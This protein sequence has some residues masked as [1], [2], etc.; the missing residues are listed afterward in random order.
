MV[1]KAGSFFV[2]EQTNS[3]GQRYGVRVRGGDLAVKAVAAG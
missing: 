3:F 2:G 1:G